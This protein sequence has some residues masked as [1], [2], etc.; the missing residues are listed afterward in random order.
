MSRYWTTFGF[1]IPPWILWSLVHEQWILTDPLFTSSVC[2]REYVHIYVSC[3]LATILKRRVFTYALVRVLEI[4]MC[5]YRIWYNKYI[6]IISSTCVLIV[7]LWSLDIV[8]HGTL[9]SSLER[10]WRVNSAADIFPF[11]SILSFFPSYSSIFIFFYL[12]F[13][14]FF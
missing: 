11:V 1:S 10:W 14:L 2:H 4:C 13:S 5:L 6:Y 7:L 12:R 3:H 8:V 9:S